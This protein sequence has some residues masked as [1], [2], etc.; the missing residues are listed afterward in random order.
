MKRV[1]VLSLV[2]SIMG[3][4]LVQAAFGHGNDGTYS[5]KDGVG[6]YKNK[7]E[8][9]T[10]QIYHDTNANTYIITMSGKTAGYLGVGFGRTVMMKDAELIMGYVSNKVVVLEHFYGTERTKAES[11]SK[12]DKNI[13][14]QVLEALSGEE[15]N[16]ITTIQFS[17]PALLEGPYYKVFQSGQTIEFIYSLGKF[18]DFSKR[19]AERGGFD[20]VIP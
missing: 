10:M 13:T 3:F 2:I 8:N 19:H 4:A 7:K 11:L 16:G 15:T 14:N 20:I 12:L 18:D 6:T 1:L 17:R 9:F 5:I